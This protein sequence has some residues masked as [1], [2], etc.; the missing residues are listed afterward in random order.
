MRRACGDG[1]EGGDA[2]PSDPVADAAAA[3]QEALELCRAEDRHDE[4]ERPHRQLLRTRGS[5]SV[6]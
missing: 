2:D 3:W 4:S 1:V 5:S 6:S